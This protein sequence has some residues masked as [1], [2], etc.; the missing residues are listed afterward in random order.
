MTAMKPN[1][2][3]EKRSPREP[4]L[5]DVERAIEAADRSVRNGVDLMRALIKSGWSV[6]SEGVEWAGLV[7]E[8]VKVIRDAL[9]VQ[10]RQ[11][12][13][14]AEVERIPISGRQEGADR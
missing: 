3:R 1:N 4:S 7:V 13:K 12:G 11:Y 10:Q 9:R 14:P 2:R 8:R 6:S 5:Q